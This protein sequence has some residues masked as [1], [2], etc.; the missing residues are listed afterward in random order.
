MVGQL[1]SILPSDMRVNED[2]THPHYLILYG[3]LHRKMII[4]KRQNCLAEASNHRTKMD[5]M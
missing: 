5:V 1:C 4:R 2:S 3:C